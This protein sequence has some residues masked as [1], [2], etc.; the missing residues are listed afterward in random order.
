[1]KL[2]VVIVTY[3]RINLLKECIDACINQSEKFE[4]IF[5][6]NNASTDGTTEYLEKINTENIEII[7]LP[8]NIGGAGGFHKGMEQAQQYDLDYLL[9]IDD[10]AILDCNYNKEIVKYMKQNDNIYAFS[11]TVKTNNQIQF[12]HRRYLSKS[13][14]EIDSKNQDYETEYFDYDLSTFCG[15]Y[16]SMEIIR[17]VGLPC[18]EFFIW[19]DDTEYSLRIKQ[20]TKIRNINSAWLNHKTTINETKGITWKTYYGLRNQ[21]ITVKKYFSKRILIKYICQIYKMIIGGKIMRILKNDIYYTK[22]VELH[23][24]ALEDGL[25]NKVGKNLKYIPGIEIKKKR[26]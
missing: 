24:D 17:K 25:N 3:N 4:K 8:E 13:F 14:N 21:I 12:G 6:V 16:I 10:D 2:G 9:L 1:M 20:F 11:G 23:R 5:V 15:L 18:K 26:D 22:L 7:T 19:Y